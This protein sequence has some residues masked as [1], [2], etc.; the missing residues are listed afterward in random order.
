[1]EEFENGFDFEQEEVFKKE[2]QKEILRTY[3]KAFLN[4]T[5]KD[6][7]KEQLTQDE[8][9]KWNSYKEYFIETKFKQEK[10][11]QEIKEMYGIKYLLIL[12][13]LGE[14]ENIKDDFDRQ[15]LK[16][17]AVLSD[18][19]LMAKE[20]K[21]KVFCDNVLEVTKCWEAS[22]DNIR[23]VI[24][25]LGESDRFVLPWTSDTFWRDWDTKL[26]FEQNEV[27]KSVVFHEK[28]KHIL[29]PTKYSFVKDI[30]HKEKQNGILGL[31][32]VA[33]DNYIRGF[34]V[35]TILD[36]ICD[37]EELSATIK[38]D[39]LQVSSF[40]ITVARMTEILDEIQIHEADLNEETTKELKLMFKRYQGISKKNKNEKRKAVARPQIEAGL[41]FY[42][43]TSLRSK[44]KTI[45]E[46]Q[47][48]LQPRI[49]R[50]VSDVQAYLSENGG[51]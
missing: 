44:A 49:K 4:D 10:E 45:F 33:L 46:K 43:R 30:Q 51:W 13:L 11:M 1:M 34:T 26:L 22:L 41:S 48:E 27:I 9:K 29:N 2:H 40:K 50:I 37:K 19:L 3:G 20:E 25:D 17:E 31:I 6:F 47:M 38:K 5:I 21:L 7:K 12:S 24:K 23:K 35:E 42:E 16:I 18:I 15:N 14:Y 39:I 8:L 32:K 28:Y 36:V